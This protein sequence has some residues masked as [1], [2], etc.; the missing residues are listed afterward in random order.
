M[1]W[2]FDTSIQWILITVTPN[3][4]AFFSFLSSS[5][6]SSV[7]FPYSCIFLTQY[8]LLGPFLEASSRSLSK[9]PDGLSSGSIISRSGFRLPRIYKF[10]KCWTGPLEFHLHL[11]GSFFYKFSK[12]MYHCTEIITGLS[13]SGI[14]WYF[15]LSFRTQ[16]CF[17]LFFTKFLEYYRK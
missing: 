1:L 16:H 5:F 8:V 14:L 4:F 15:F 12:A 11:R 6:L 17:F 9:E 10:I 3:S 7:C 13:K 2:N